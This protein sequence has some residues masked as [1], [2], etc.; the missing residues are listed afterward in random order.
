MPSLPVA[1]LA[2][3]RWIRLVFPP[4]PGLLRLRSAALATLA[5][6]LTFVVALAASRLMSL[7][8][9]VEVFGFAAGLLVVASVRDETLE[10]QKRTTLLTA[11]PL[12]G[13]TLL[14][15]L[16][17]HFPLALDALLVAIIG[18]TLYAAALGPRYVAFGNIAVTAQL[19][20]LIAPAPMGEIG[21]RL[22]VL[23]IGVLIAYGV[24][25]GPLGRP[26]EADV[27]A[28][29]LDIRRTVAGLLTL[30]ARSLRGGTLTE[31][32]RTALE[33]ASGRLEAR[34]AVAQAKLSLT[35]ATRPLADHLLAVEF[36][37]ERLLRLAAG[38]L[39][40]EDAARMI[41]LAPRLVSALAGRDGGAAPELPPATSPFA[42]HLAALERQI[43]EPPHP[44][45]ALSAAAPAADREAAER[46]ARHQALQACLAVG[47]A[48]AVGHLV[49]PN[50]WYWAAFTA[51]VVFQGAHGRQDSAL[52]A[53]QLFIGTAAGAVAGVVIAT[54]LATTPLL[55][56]AA[57]IVATFL[58]FNA[59]T[60]AYGVSVFWVTIIIALVFGLLG[61][62]PGELVALRV[63]ETLVGGGLGL[64]TSLLV[65]LD[66]AP[67]S[68]ESLR[69]DDLRALARLV[70]ASA[71]RFSGRSA[72]SL[73]PAM[74]EA[75]RCFL[76][77][78]TAA[79]PRLRGPLALWNRNAR[80]HL[81]LLR[82]CNHWARELAQLAASPG[83]APAPSALHTVEGVA[84]RIQTMAETLAAR[85][86]GAAP[87]G[88]DEAAVPSAGAALGGDPRDLRAVKLVRN[89][90]TALGRCLG[91]TSPATP[92]GPAGAS[93]AGA[94][95][96]AE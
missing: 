59:S 84:A 83:E 11:V 27:A 24:R 66:K 56:I 17:S 44:D 54:L 34:M 9:N 39:A 14:T 10:A 61:Y 26:P 46:L 95:T 50:R 3:T 80:S 41:T 25:F 7:A 75:E 78:S 23:M 49:S 21:D 82:A 77:L 15:A 74:A 72:E 22:L 58:A 69:R 5:G 18:A 91:E 19:F 52:K 38:P 47:L 2:L 70:T 89:I 1:A 65:R 12:A 60:A 90:E 53:W 85:P 29:D 88:F 79:G 16:L 35:P 48:M 40:P 4:D 37:L 32:G 13:L 6:F 86:L 28:V 87:S 71:E 64:V 55:A 57:S 36:A 42:L 63:E 94:P 73:S 62:F 33:A 96:P 76:A 68:L 51:F 31:T 30:L 92:A 81:V 8:P 93:S 67:D 45:P 20:G 43:L